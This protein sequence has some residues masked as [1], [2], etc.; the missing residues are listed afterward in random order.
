MECVMELIVL[1][2]LVRASTYLH[3]S[4]HL[5]TR[6]PTIAALIQLLQSWLD[7]YSTVI[8]TCISWSFLNP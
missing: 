3:G 2:P 6:N 1:R 5:L 8:P 4:W 7:I